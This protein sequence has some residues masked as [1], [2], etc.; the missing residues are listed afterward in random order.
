MS[1]YRNTKYCPSLIGIGMRKQEVRRSVLSDHPQAKDMHA[2]VSI[3]DQKYKTE[4]MKAYN[5]KCAYC[6]VSIDLISRVMFEIDH[7]VNQA[8]P[9]FGG[10]KK[11]AGTIENLVLAC[12]DCNHSKSGFTI[13]SE[14]KDALNPDGELISSYYYRDDM[15][16]IKPTDAT[17]NKVDASLFYSKLHLGS[18]I[19]RIDY[20]VMSMI[21]LQKELKG[22]GKEYKELSDAISTLKEKRNLMSL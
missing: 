17:K 18:E 21:G 20:L 15:Y 11:K 14:N 8:S 1:D 6:G 9:E 16:Y 2:Y 22:K 3:N 4:F 12:H 5:F 10:S 13:T 19:H 7:F